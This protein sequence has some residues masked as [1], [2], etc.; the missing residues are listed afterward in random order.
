[1]VDIRLSVE[2]M[3]Y[4]ITIDPTRLFFFSVREQGWRYRH[5]H[6]HVSIYIMASVVIKLNETYLKSTLNV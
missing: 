4:G 2:D 3:M 6:K 1:M 5:K